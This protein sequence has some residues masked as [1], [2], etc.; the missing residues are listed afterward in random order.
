[1]ESATERHNR[2]TKERCAARS[3][4]QRAQDNEIRRARRSAFFNEPKSSNRRE[5][6]AHRASLTD[7]A[8]EALRE[9]NRVAHACQRAALGD[10]AREVLREEN[11]VAHA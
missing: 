6:V 8:R 1:M 9:E 11:R 5:Q 4:E 2:L 3:V 7:E 10:D